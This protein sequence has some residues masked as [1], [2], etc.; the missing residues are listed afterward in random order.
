MRYSRHGFL[1]CQ[2]L[3]TNGKNPHYVQAPLKPES[4]DV[5]DL[6]LEEQEQL[7]DEYYRPL[8]E[9]WKQLKLFL[10]AGDTLKS[11]LSL[12]VSTGY[13]PLRLMLHGDSL[14]AL[15]SLSIRRIYFRAIESPRNAIFKSLLCW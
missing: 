13:G 7:S 1:L 2:I 5:E 6:N 10:V 9:R 4:E 15:L 12:D 3:L 11:I 8:W 14:P